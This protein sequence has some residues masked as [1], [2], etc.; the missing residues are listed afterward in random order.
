MKAPTIAGC[1][2]L[3]VL[4]VGCARHPEAASD[5]P[6]VIAFADQPFALGYGRE[7]QIAG[8]ALRVRFEDVT[9]D[10]RCPGGRVQCV[11]AGNARIILR[12]SSTSGSQLDTLSLTLEPHRSRFA[13]HSIAFEGLAPAPTPDSHPSKEQYVATLRV[14]AAP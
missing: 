11:W 2:G 13:G 5:G 3:G 8:G 12:V 9:E 1:I 7:A 10:S 6:L 4:G 14:S